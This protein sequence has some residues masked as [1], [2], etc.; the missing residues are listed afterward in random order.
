MP[1]NR[2]FS[3]P[4]IPHTQTLENR[5]RPFLLHGDQSSHL[6]PL[7]PF[8]Q[9]ALTKAHTRP[10]DTQ[11]NTPPRGPCAYLPAE[12]FHKPCT[13]RPGPLW[14]VMLPPEDIRSLTMPWRY[15]NRTR[16]PLRGG[17]QA[18]HEV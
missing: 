11:N 2:T 9:P 12:M 7:P 8:L 14:N 18:S 13:A 15:Y 1:L 17:M 3:T 6:Y 10:L 16:T 5:T 4:L